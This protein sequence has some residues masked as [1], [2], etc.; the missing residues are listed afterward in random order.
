MVA[1][2]KWL[3]AQFRMFNK[4]YFH[5]DLPTVEVEF[6]K[7]ED[8]LRCAETCFDHSGAPYKISLDTYLTELKNYA[9]IVLLHEMIHVA[10]GNKE[11]AY[12]GQMWK[13]ERKRLIDAG[14]FTP[15]L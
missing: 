5:D 12:H 4:R 3:R 10:V 7:L 8:Q 9:K 11:K 1:D 15:M 13:K 6:A 14:A 2:N